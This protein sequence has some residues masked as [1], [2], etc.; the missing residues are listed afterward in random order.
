[1]KNG[2]WATHGACGKHR[3]PAMYPLRDFDDAGGLMGYRPDLAVQ[4]GRATDYVD[5]ILSSAS[6]ADLP[7]EQP[8]QYLFVVNLKTAKAG[9][10]NPG[11]DLAARRRRDSVMRYV[12]RLSR[13][14]GL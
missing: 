11:V 12:C 2:P 14:S 8:T 13:Q 6:P 9:A 4:F 3:L 10:D 7:I 5:K 1:M